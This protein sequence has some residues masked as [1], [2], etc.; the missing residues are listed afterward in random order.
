VVSVGAGVTP[1]AELLDQACGASRLLLYLD[2]DGTLA[3]L[4]ANPDRCALT[5]PLPEILN[6]LSASPRLDLAVISG[7]SL[8]DLQRHLPDDLSQINLAGNHGLELQCRGAYWADPRAV[9]LRPELD[10]LADWGRALLQDLPGSSIE[11]KALS[12]SLHGRGVPADRAGELEERLTPLVAAVLTSAELELRRGRCVLEIRPAFP[13]GKAF[14]AQ[15][16]EQD[17]L[18]RGFW[19]PGLNPEPL[20]LY[21]G[22]DQTDEDVFLHWPGVIGIHVGPGSADTA[23]AYRLGGPVGLSQWL[24]ALEHRLTADRLSIHH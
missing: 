20:R 3:R 7:R 22:D 4:R 16:L 6:T 21:F 18:S 5:P 11:H 14:A 23:A 1:L 15:Q 8:H 9:A 2:Y 10:R 13:H 24:M 17:A 12:L 19:R